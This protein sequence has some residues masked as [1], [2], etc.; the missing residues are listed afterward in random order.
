VGLMYLLK[1][2]FSGNNDQGYRSYDLKNTSHYSATDRPVY[3]PSYNPDIDPSEFD[4]ERKK[5]HP[6][7]TEDE[8]R[9][10]MTFLRRYGGGY[11]KYNQGRVVKRD[12]LGKEKGIL[13]GIFF[14]VI[15]PGRNF[16]DTLK[17]DFRAYLLSIGVNGLSEKPDYEKIREKTITKKENDTLIRSS[18]H[19]AEKR[20]NDTLFYLLN[21]QDKVFKNITLE[22]NGTHREYDHIVISGSTILIL[23]TKGFG[24]SASLGTEKCTLH[25]DEND[26][27]V[28]EKNGNTRNL[29]SPT[30]QI[31]GQK[32]IIEGILSGTNAKIEYILV[33][34][35][36]EL[37]CDFH[38]TRNYMIM[39]LLELSLAFEK[40]TSQNHAASSNLIISKIEQHR[41]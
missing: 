36:P 8:I 18:G 14:N 27:W 7:S 4:T 32:Q 26:N 1:K 9:S 15:L 20:V 5:I 29:K 40:L 10:F 30:A 17:E 28:I 21:A 2:L 6:Y 23:E 25:I 22:Y 38:G 37:E 33:L 11:V 31:T 41:I 35:N 16:S 12:F 39:T 24:I 34:P 3:V 19:K 13:K